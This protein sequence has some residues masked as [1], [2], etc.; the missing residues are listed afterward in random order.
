MP[1]Y[2]LGQMLT[3]GEKNF[4]YAGK[5]A[6]QAKKMKISY[7]YYTLKRLLTQLP[8]ALTNS[9]PKTK[10][11]LPFFS[12]ISYTPGQML[13]EHKIYFNPLYFKMTVD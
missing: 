8:S 7:I 9:E 13:A 6:N 1:H 11:I 2:T 4:L 5:N 12:N 10:K 3:K